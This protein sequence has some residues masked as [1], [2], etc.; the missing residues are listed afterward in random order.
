M[1]LCNVQSSNIKTTEESVR[2]LHRA[3]F[4]PCILHIW[5]ST[6]IPWCACNG[7]AESSWLTLNS[8]QVAT[9][10]Y[11]C[12]ERAKCSIIPSF[13][14]QKTNEVINTMTSLQIAEITGKP[15]NDVM[16]AIRKMEPAWEKVHQGKFSLMS[17]EIEIG[18]GA[19]RE[20]PCYELTKTECLY[21][22]TKFNDEARAKLILR[23]EQLEREKM[24][25]QNRVPTSF[26]EALLLAAQQQEHIE[27][28]QRMLE[29]KEAE[30]E[31]LESKVE[32]MDV[33]V[34]YVDRILAN[35]STC[36]TSSI[37]Q[38]YGMSAVVF[39]GLL[40][41]LGI[42]RRVGKQWILYAPF[43]DK[44]YVHSKAIEITLSNGQRKVHYHTEWTQ[45]GRMFLYEEL[46]SHGI[47]PMIERV[48]D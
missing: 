32:E 17:R 14:L 43:L 40:N 46:K 29:A 27:R 24:S 4:M 6:L 16:K 8:G 30:V 2:A 37:A 19:R 41:T 5:R 34:R 25:W 39:N 38:D 1:Y 36:V 11:L 35:S 15:H 31:V 48:N 47:V 13:M 42:Q 28:Q 10:L 9:P 45:R 26:R 20:V 18:N 22:A 12:K 33:K 21:I 23:W 3:F 7:H 44:G